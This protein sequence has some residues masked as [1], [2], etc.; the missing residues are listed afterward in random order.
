MRTCSYT[1]FDHPAAK[2]L[3]IPNDKGI[4]GNA[5]VKSYAD[6]NLLFRKYDAV[7]DG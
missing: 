7:N 1:N 4:E 2:S 5:N 6:I 3:E